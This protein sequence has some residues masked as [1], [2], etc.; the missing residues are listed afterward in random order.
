MLIYGWLTVSAIQFNHPI[1]LPRNWFICLYIST[2]NNQFSCVTFRVR[3]SLAF[4]VKSILSCPILLFSLCVLICIWITKIFFFIG[5]LNNEYA[6][7]TM[8]AWLQ[9]GDIAY[10]DSDGYLYIVGRLKDVI[11]YKGFQV[12]RLPITGHGNLYSLSCSCGFHI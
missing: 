9:T 10:F 8:D 2:W 1:M 4:H 6:C 5:Y 7:L 12:R 11:K 3:V